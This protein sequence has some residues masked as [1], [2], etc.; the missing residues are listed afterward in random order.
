MHS[1]EELVDQGSRGR[2]IATADMN[3]GRRGGGHRDRVNRPRC[4]PALERLLRHGQGVVPASEVS[5]HPRHLA[6]DPHRR[7]P[8][9]FG[10][11]HADLIHR[12]ARRRALIDPER[13]RKVDRGDRRPG[14]AGVQHD[15]EAPAQIGEPTR[16]A[17]VAP[18]HS[19]CGER[20]GQVAGPT[21]LLDDGKR[22]V[23]GRDGLVRLLS[24]HEDR[25]VDRQSARELRAGERLQQFDRALRQGELVGRA[26]GRQDGPPREHPAE[27]AI[28]AELDGRGFG[29]V[30]QTA[31]RLEVGAK[32]V[33]GLDGLYEGGAEPRIAVL[34]Q[35]AGAGGE[36]SG[37]RGVDA[38]RRPTGDQEVIDR[39]ASQHL[40]DRT[41]R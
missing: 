36:P 9:A 27:G 18:A 2:E 8:A 22:R 34:E 41:S 3:R 29:P 31:L 1:L 14:A 10:L 11:P 32:R 33:S 13:A 17:P 26:V 35:V 6:L 30:K 25:G 39:R 20:Q 21:E 4:S 16:I 12:E 5:E 38:H 19:A 7:L 15:I 37:G 40:A 24:E 28:V 23:G